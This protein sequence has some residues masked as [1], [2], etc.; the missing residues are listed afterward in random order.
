MYFFRAINEIDLQNIDLINRIKSKNACND[1]KCLDSVS[2]HISG[3]SDSKYSSC[4]I[5]SSKNFK[6]CACEFSIPQMGK[7]NTAKTRKKL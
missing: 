5:S 4:W 1:I 3:G 7:Y 6:V 2:S